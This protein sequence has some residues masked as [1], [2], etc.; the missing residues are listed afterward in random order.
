M[1][2][3]TS[4]LGYYLGG[5]G[6]IQ[7]Y[8]VLLYLLAG[9]ALSCGGTAVLNNYIERMHDAKMKRTSRRALPSGQV[10][11]LF[12]L[13]YGRSL[14]ALG[15]GLLIWQINVITAT[16]AAITAI[17]YVVVYTPLKRV[18]WLNTSIGAIPGA[19]PAVGGWTAA[20]GEI[21]LGA[22]V[23]FGIMFFWQHPHFY[24]IAWMYKDDYER[25]GYK[26]LPRFDETGEKTVA[27]SLV[28]LVFLF[29]VSLIPAFSSISGPIYLV[30]ASAAGLMMLASG[31]MFAQSRHVRE[32]RKLMFASLLYL[33]ILLAVF[34]LDAVVVA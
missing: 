14:V 27:H 28:H 10:T 25:G 12:A 18:T 9:T 2:M 13:W 22:W 34:V 4:L 30:G 8:L 6:K 1:V 24:A 16:L 19:L 3:V 31:C 17:M 11:P 29:V 33:P 32:A 15:V 5:G 26:M 23:L 7:S 20:T 21:G